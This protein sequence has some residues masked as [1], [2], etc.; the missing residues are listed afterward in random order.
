MVIN[1]STR[2]YKRRSIGPLEIIRTIQEMICSDRK[3]IVI[4]W[5]IH[6][7]VSVVAIEEGKIFP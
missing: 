1:S 2:D 6:A 7:I 5:E 3:G 4:A